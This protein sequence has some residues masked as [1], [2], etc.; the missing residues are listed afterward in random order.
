[1]C[2][3]WPIFTE[4]F[5]RRARDCDSAWELETLKTEAG[6]SKNATKL[7]LKCEFYS[8]RMEDREDLSKFVDRVA[9]IV[10]KLHDVGC[11][12]SESE[13]CYKIL[14]SLP[15]SYRSMTL[16][17]LMMPEEQLTVHV[18]RQQFSSLEKTTHQGSKSKPE[19]TQALHTSGDNKKEG[20]FACGKPG[21]FKNQCRASAEEK[22]AYAEKCRRD[23]EQKKANNNN[24]NS[25]GAKGKKASTHD[26]E[27]EAKKEEIAYSFHNP[28]AKSVKDS[29]IFDSGSITSHES[30]QEGDED[31]SEW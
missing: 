17:C 15:T 31:C 6:G 2:N 14:A 20:C 11:T 8:A 7:S 24:K 3:N 13:V 1:M 21:H 26:A 23:G 22:A 27:G 5:Y 10:D 30:E 29:W 25:K 12:T 16:A 18:L 4:K 19:K 28:V 9:I